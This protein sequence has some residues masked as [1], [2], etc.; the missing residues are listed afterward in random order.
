PILGS[1]IILI[2]WSIIM[3]FSG[4]I[5]SA[6]ILITVYLL[7]QVTRQLLEPKLIGKSMGAKP[8][9]TLISIYVGV[10]LFSGYGYFLGPIGLAII[11]ATI[12]V[13]ADKLKGSNEDFDN[14]DRR[15]ST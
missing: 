3:L 15:I 6:A 7:C 8:L 4:N 2:P 14:N 13:V 11:L 12:G 1:G 10:Q 9:F 5:Y